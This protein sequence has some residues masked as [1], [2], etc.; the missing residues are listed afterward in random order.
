MWQLNMPDTDLVDYVSM[1]VGI[2]IEA[3]F[4]DIKERQRQ[5]SIKR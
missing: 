2:A 5:D 1:R 3:V 4:N